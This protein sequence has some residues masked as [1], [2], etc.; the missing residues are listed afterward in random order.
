MRG[1]RN[2]KPD[3]KRGPIS[4]EDKTK[5][6]NWCKTK[7][8]EEIGRLIGR[9]EK[10]V[11]TYRQFYLARAPQIEVERTE[12]E[13]YRL[14]L[15]TDMDWNRLQKEFTREELK[16]FENDYINYRGQLKDITT[17]EKKQL[18]NL[19]TLNI[20]MHR[21]NTDRMKVQEDIKRL[22]RLVEA[23]YAQPEER[24]NRDR[25][26]ELEMYI[27]TARSATASQTKEYKDLLE[28]SQGL[29]RD[30]KTTR[31]QRIKHLEDRGKFIVFLK[32]LE[33]EDRRK[34]IG[35]IVGLM[36]LAVDKEK[37]RLTSLHTFA[38]GMIDKPLLIPDDDN[39]STELDAD[40]PEE[41]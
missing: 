11:A 7:T 33:Q 36:D 39:E 19:I 37:R 34:G 41:L 12:A 29:A 24:Q 9:P 1:K 8:D 35:E 26:H 28:K 38:D 25:I 23:E 15:H 13:Q 30:L 3:I 40:A 32:E 10:Q 27:Q 21:H 31:D 22:E 2:T 5:I 18:F 14:E 16:Y 6:E 20:F 17:S 4:R